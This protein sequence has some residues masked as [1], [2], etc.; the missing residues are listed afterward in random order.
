MFVLDSFLSAVPCKDSLKIST[1]FLF[2]PAACSFLMLKPARIDAMFG[3]C[4]ESLFITIKLLRRSG[5]DYSYPA[6]IM[7]TSGLREELTK[8]NLILSALTTIHC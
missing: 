1:A 3:R 5:G 7:T 8:S 2:R 6:F 4:I